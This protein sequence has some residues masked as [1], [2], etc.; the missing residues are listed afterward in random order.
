MPLSQPS[1]WKLEILCLCAEAVLIGP[2]YYFFY[3][4]L[5]LVA[6]ALFSRGK[7]A[8]LQQFTAIR[9]CGNCSCQ[10][11]PGVL[12]EFKWPPDYRGVFLEKMA[13]LEGWLYGLIQDWSPSSPPTL[14]S[15]DFTFR[16]PVSN[17]WQLFFSPH[18]N[19][20]L[21]VALQTPVVLVWISGLSIMAYVKLQSEALKWC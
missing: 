20:N 17:L 7:R 19:N 16:S 6:L 10:K 8:K 11:G 4:G 21:Y 12:L 3:S 14:P 15:P 18:R 2:Q 13:T 9:N 5:L 1:L